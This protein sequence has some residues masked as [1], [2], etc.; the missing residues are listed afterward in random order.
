MRVEWIEAL[1]RATGG[2]RSATLITV[3][4]A[5]DRPELVGR[6]LVVDA[7]G[8]VAGELAGELAEDGLEERIRQAAERML[9]GG[10]VATVWVD[11]LRLYMELIT[12]PPA[13]VVAG[14]GHVAQPLAVIGKL[15][16]YRVIV[17]DDRPD[18][19]NRDRFPDVDQVICDDFTAAL[20]ALEPGA[21]HSVVLVTRS[22]LH[23]Y[24]CLKELIGRPLAYVGMIGSH[25]RVNTVFRK[26][27]ADGTDRTAL[28]RVHAPVGLDIGARSPA[29]IAVSIAAE[30]IRS[31]G[32][33][34]GQPLSRL[35][36]ARIHGR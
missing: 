19:A 31:Q 17:I 23:D 9:S 26:L 3:V 11:D 8:P 12:P 20:R 32:G 24:Q 13:L 7:A 14:A 6:H 30:L 33:G 18:Y 22:Y 2:G 1:S 15:L 4:A 28:G 34:T 35:G 16:G 5:P 21:H 10:S 25:N 36:L 27:I 29:A